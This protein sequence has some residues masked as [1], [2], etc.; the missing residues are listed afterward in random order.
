MFAVGT[1]GEGVVFVVEYGDE[2][3]RIHASYLP[4][5]EVEAGGVRCI[6]EDGVGHGA[7]GFPGVRAR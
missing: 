7:R 5:A 1:R 4:Y 3:V 6:G 2:G